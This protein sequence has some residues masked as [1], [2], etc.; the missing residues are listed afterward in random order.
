MEDRE[1]LDLLFALQEQALAELR[2]KYGSYCFGIACNILGSREDAEE[3]VNDLWYQVWRTVPPQRP[4]FLRLYLGSIVRN[5]AFSRWRRSNAE[6]RG[7]GE[8]P[9]VLDEL[10][11]CIPGGE[12]PDAALDARELAQSIRAFLD[13]LPERERNIFLGRYFEAAATES[14]AQHYGLREDNVRRILSRTRK[15]LKDYLKKEGYD[16]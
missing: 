1:I 10:G 8:V 4:R 11:D 9:L 5:L 7:G 2:R 14:L 6:K 13:G 3:T 15:K 12:R 16:L